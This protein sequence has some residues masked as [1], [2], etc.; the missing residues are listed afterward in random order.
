MLSK[1]LLDKEDAVEMWMEV[2][3]LV[4]QILIQ[5]PIKQLLIILLLMLHGQELVGMATFNVQDLPEVY[6]LVLE[7]I[8]DLVMQW[9]MY[10]AVV[11]THGFPFLLLPQ[12]NPVIFPSGLVVEE[13]SIL[14]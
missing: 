12:C 7:K 13:I 6:Q 4:L 1:N 10:Q 8:L 11:I 2:I 5:I 9:T 3:I 14:Q